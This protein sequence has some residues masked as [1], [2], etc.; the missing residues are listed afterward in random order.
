MTTNA[1]KRMPVN[2]DSVSVTDGATLFDPKAGHV[3][4]FATCPQARDWKGKTRG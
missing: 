3:S 1:G 4:H 2:A